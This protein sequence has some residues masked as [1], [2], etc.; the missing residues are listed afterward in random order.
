[1]LYQNE[2]IIINTYWEEIFNKGI[3]QESA[4]NPRMEIDETFQEDKEM[5]QVSELIIHGYGHT[6]LIDDFDNNIL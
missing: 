2:G 3:E 1:M 5:E 4:N 6:H